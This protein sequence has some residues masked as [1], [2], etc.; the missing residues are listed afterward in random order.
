MAD[1]FYPDE[2]KYTKD[3]DWLSVDGD[4]AT[5]GLSHFAQSALG[6]IVFV[7]LP[8]TGSTITTDEPF[9]VIESIKSV[10]DL[11]GPVNG[12]VIEAN[13]EVVNAPESLNSAPYDSWLI[14]VKL[15][16]PNEL[17]KTMSSKN[18]KSYCENS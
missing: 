1:N 15:S 3:H 13:E 18:Y 2:L 8:E 6:D 12:E 11:M 14:K 5:I 17:S 9:G 4:I 7:E 10:T 16:S